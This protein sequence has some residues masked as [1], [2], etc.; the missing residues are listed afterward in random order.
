MNKCNKCRKIKINDEFYINEKSGKLYTNCIECVKIIRLS[1]L[2]E[3][4]KKFENGHKCPDCGEL[5]SFSEYRPID[6]KSWKF[7]KSC[8]QCMKI[9]EKKREE[10]SRAYLNTVYSG[11]DN[12]YVENIIFQK[13]LKKGFL[14]EVKKL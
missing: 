4:K 5:K 14:E 2:N 12:W 9:R 1:A 7:S 11:Y 6:A 10:E 3:R 8:D 13:Y